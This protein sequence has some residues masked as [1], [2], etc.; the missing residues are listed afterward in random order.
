MH[1]EHIEETLNNLCELY[2]QYSS[3]NKKVYYFSKLAV[4]ELS[5]WIEYVIDEAIKKHFLISSDSIKKEAEKSIKKC[6]GFEYDFNVRPLVKT[7]LGIKNLDKIEQELQ[8]DE[9]L[10]IIKD[11]LGYLTK[12]RQDFA[13]TFE[14]SRSHPPVSP[15]VTLQIFQAIKKPILKFINLIEN[16]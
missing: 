7:T 16:S 1:I 11:K 15:T 5:G 12:V 3:E 14:M 6:Y 8:L 2:D 10:H 9:S 4:L 13:H